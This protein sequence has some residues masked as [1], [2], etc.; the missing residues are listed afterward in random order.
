MS[1]LFRQFTIKAKNHE[2]YGK[3]SNVKYLCRKFQNNYKT[4]FKGLRTEYFFQFYPLFLINLTIFLFSFIIIS[5]SEHTKQTE[6][7]LKRNRKL[8]YGNGNCFVITCFNG[9]PES[10]R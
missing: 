2:I 10:G 5:K 6:S 4:Y 3:I 7:S 8:C 1:P 9:Q